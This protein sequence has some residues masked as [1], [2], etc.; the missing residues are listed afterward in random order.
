MTGYGNDVALSEVIGFILLLGLIVAAF[1][2]YTVYVVPVNGR[3]DEI[4][5]MNYVEEQFTDYKLMVDALWTS[6]LINVNSQNPMYPVLNVNSMISSTTLRL[7]AGGTTQ[8][9]GL[10]LSLFKP[11]PSTGILSIVTTGDTFNIDS[12][13][14]HNSTDNKG[15]FPINIAALEYRSDNYY[16]IQQWYSYQLGGV[17]LSQDN[18]TTNRISPLIS[19]TNAA[20]KSVVVNIVPVQVFGNRSVSGN[21]PVRVDT[22]QRI[23]P[24]YN[25]SLNQY[26]NNQWVNLSITTA[27]NATAAMW[28]NF[29]KGIVAS[30]QISSSQIVSAWNPSSK[31]TTVF[32]YI[33]GSTSN[34]LVSLYVQRAEFDVTLNIV[35]SESK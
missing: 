1:S 5:Q 30:E 26:R 19:I 10:S 31:R 11:I 22:R 18:G 17:F 25:I 2:L 3:E 32:I 13:S 35:A 33:N 14:Y 29:F 12:S 21:N 15:E 9:G 34:P 23:L 20:N 16:W 7:G 6:Y 28:L 8:P 24:N 27:D 4:T